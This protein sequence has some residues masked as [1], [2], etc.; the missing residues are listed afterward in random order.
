MSRRPRGVPINQVHRRR[1]CNLPLPAKMLFFVFVL[2][3]TCVG[4]VGWASA[5]QAQ[6]HEFTGSSYATYEVDMGSDELRLF[7]KSP[8][9]IPFGNF[10]VLRDSLAAEGIDVVFATNAGIFETTMR[11]L[12]LHIED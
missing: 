9:G 1:G 3:I 7:W 2:G 5:G 10:G 8:R 11:P 12:G 4:L 6:R